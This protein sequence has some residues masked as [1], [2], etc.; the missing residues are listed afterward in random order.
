MATTISFGLSQKEIKQAIKQLE[1][2]KVGFNRKLEI[3]VRRLMEIG[4]V[5]AA[6]CL[7][8]LNIGRTVRLKTD[9]EPMVNGCRGILIGIGKDITND[10]GTINTL[11]LIEFGAGIHHNPTDN[12]KAAELGMGVGTFPGQTHSFDDGGWFYLNDND[13]WVHTYGTKATMPMFNAS[14][15]IIL[16]AREIAKDVFK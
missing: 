3:Y 1:R 15:E 6:D 8:Q 4:H 14:R 13:E 5:K 10:Y 12:P 7:G 11:L 2:Y 16:R 9:I